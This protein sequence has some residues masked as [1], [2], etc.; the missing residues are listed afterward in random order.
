MVK[1]LRYLLRYLLLG[2]ML[3]GSGCDRLAPV[4]TA[5]ELELAQ[6]S[7]A[8]DAD[9]KSLKSR[10]DRVLAAGLENRRLSTRDNAAW[11]IMHGVICYGRKLPLDTPDRG[12]VSAVDYAFNEG[13]IRGWQLMP[14]S[15]LPNGR[16]G[17]KALL[18]AGSYTGQG[19][20][21]QWIAICAMAELP[22]TDEVV[23]EGERYTLGDWAEQARWDACTNPLNEFSWTLIASTYYF[24]DQPEWIA[25]DGSTWSWERMVAEEV[26]Y[27]LTM[28]PCGGAHRL[29]GLARALAAKKRLNLPD[30]QVWDDARR[31]VEG[32]VRDIEAMRSGDGSLS[33]HYLERPGSSRDLALT[34][35]SSGHLLEFLANAL[36]EEQLRQPWVE[37]AAARLCEIFEATTTVD[38]D[39]GA[40]YHGLNGLRVYRNRRFGG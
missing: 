5:E 30:S 18:E 33:S 34:L 29:V 20:V 4:P 9:T 12:L 2:G 36:D 19:H 16:R 10:I 32:S 37:T 31:T 1:A 3:V 7:S 35:A 6:V 8:P 27:D 14:G 24:P 26:R 13:T 40:F 25:S 22:A 15:K 21:D 11:Q 17:V 38:L 28:S 39:C 23:V